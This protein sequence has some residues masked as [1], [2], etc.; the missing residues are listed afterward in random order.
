MDA[1]ALIGCVPGNDALCPSFGIQPL[2]VA[3]RPTSMPTY[4]AGNGQWPGCLNL[5]P[6]A[7]HGQATSRTTDGIGGT[8][9]THVSLFGQMAMTAAWGAAAGGVSGFRVPGLTSCGLLPNAPAALLSQAC[10]GGTENVQN[11]RQM[12]HVRRPSGHQGMEQPQLL[13]RSRGRPRKRRMVALSTTR[14]D[15]PGDALQAGI[16]A[17]HGSGGTDLVSFFLGSI[18]LP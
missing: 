9:F 8:G 18:S 16:D 5:C 14:N 6:A 3:T 7:P 10:R 13:K 1:K 15:R 11:V 4:A 2:A 12:A 17:C